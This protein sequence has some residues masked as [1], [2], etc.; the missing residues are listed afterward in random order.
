MSGIEAPVE[1]VSLDPNQVIILVIGVVILTDVPLDDGGVGDLG[2]GWDVL[3]AEG[4]C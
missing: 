1:L 2:D 3:Q 4:G